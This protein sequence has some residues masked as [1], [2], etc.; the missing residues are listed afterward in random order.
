MISSLVLAIALL[1]GQD[2]PA[3]AAP[4]QTPAAP[5]TIHL[6][7]GSQVF[8][9]LA[10]PLSSKTSHTGDTFALRLIEPVKQGDT[11]IIPAGATGQGEVVDAGPAGIYGKQ[12]KLNISAR[13][14]T[15]NGQT[16]PIRGMNLTTS[17]FSQ[18][19]AATGMMLVPY[20]GIAAFVVRGGDIDLPAGTKGVAKLVADLDITEPVAAAA[21]NTTP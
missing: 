20:V 8:V 16:V 4:L 5:R 14:L 12:G 6:P 19:D 2:A 9:E 10:Q 3:V 7:A 18:V 13:S 17:G 21:P 15:I 11:V 1:S